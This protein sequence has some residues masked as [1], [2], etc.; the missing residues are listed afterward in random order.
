MGTPQDQRDWIISTLMPYRDK[1][2]G[3]VTGNHEA[4]IYNDVGL[5]ISKDIA[6]ALKV[7]YRSE[8]I[9][10]KIMFGDG[11]NHVKDKPYVYWCYMTHGYGGARTSSAKAIKVERTS[12]WIHADFYIMSHDHVVNAAPVVYLYP[13]KRAH[14]DPDTGFMTGKIVAQR[15]MLIKSNSYVKWGGYAERGGFS[16]NDLECPIIHLAGEGRPRVRVEI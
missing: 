9:L 3:M 1:I 16:P 8:G 6:E 13:D 7:P 11:N 4:R 10:L 12:S 5:D 14:I 2:L 15:K